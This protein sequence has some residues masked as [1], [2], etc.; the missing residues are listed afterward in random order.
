[1][2]RLSKHAGKDLR[3]PFDRLKVT[4]PLQQFLTPG[5]QTYTLS[6]VPFVNTA[7]NQD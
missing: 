6:H 7:D 1:M 3:S 4:T 5:K 2:L